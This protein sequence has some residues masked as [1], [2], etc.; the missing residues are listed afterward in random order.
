MNEHL[1]EMTEYEREAYLGGYDDGYL[2]G[3]DNTLD[4]V[5][6]IIDQ[7]LEEIHPPHNRLVPCIRCDYVAV[8]RVLQDRILEKV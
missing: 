6:V 3:V 7:Y 1:P 4:E 2:S 8:I 5:I